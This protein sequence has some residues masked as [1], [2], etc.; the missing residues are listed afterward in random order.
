MDGYEPKIN[1]PTEKITE[2]CRKWKIREFSFFGS[3]LRNDFRPDSD[4]DVLVEF[5]PNHGWGLYEV[6]DM[7]DE[8]KSLLGR[9]VDLVMK[10]GLHNPIRRHEIL[11][12]RKVMY[13]AGA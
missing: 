1:I 3:I 11:R 8:L 6:L 7:E 9:E 5:E 13:A 12:T 4:V 2:F 10:G